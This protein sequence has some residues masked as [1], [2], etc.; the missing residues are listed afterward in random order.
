MVVYMVKQVLELSGTLG[1]LVLWKKGE[2]NSNIDNII[3]EQ[4]GSEMLDSIFYDE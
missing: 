1:L 3:I 4:K 2:R